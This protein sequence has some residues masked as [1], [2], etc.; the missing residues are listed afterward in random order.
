MFDGV[1]HLKNM[2]KPNYQGPLIKL[3]LIE[4][5]CGIAAQSTE[6]VDIGTPGVED[7]PEDI[8]EQELF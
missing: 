7:P 3:E 4:L 5:E 6:G 2:K 1:K 8:D